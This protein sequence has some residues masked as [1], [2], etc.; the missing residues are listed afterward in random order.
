VTAG[1]LYYLVSSTIGLACLFLLVELVE[2]G[3]SPEDDVLAVTL[4]AYGDDEAE[5]EHDQEIG[6]ATPRTLAAL[7]IAFICCTL[8]IAGMPP[9]SGFLGKF[10]IISGMMGLDG[11]G[12]AAIRTEVWV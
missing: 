9:L 11:T 5:P 6:T 8:I 7:G 12:D 3:R 10:A 4:E 2:R 1:A